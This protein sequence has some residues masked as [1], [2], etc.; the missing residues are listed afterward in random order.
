MSCADSHSDDGAQ[1]MATVLGEA[2]PSVPPAMVEGN[3]PI[4]TPVSATC[5]TRKKPPFGS[6]SCRCA[7]KQY[8]S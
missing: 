6:P 7:L 3:N 4:A 2:R 8:D 1:V 5:R